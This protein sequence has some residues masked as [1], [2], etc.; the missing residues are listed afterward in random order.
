MRE[1]IKE[2]KSILF[3]EE[4]ERFIVSK[5]YDSINLYIESCNGMGRFDISRDDEI[6]YDEI[7]KLY[8]SIIEMREV[9]NHFYGPDIVKNGRIE[10]YN[11]NYEYSPANKFVISKFNDEYTLYYTEEDE[12]NKGVDI[13]MNGLDEERNIY[14]PYNKFFM[15]MYMNLK[16]H[17]YRKD[18]S[19][20]LK[21]K[22]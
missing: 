6:L 18:D 14:N 17:D 19:Y 16:K 8:K 2:E 9:R 12:D 3:G 21:L 22:K 15:R 7:D 13:C 10:L 4:G 1:V 11:W 5:T 20:T